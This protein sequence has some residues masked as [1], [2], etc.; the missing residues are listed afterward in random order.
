MKLAARF[1]QRVALS[2]CAQDIRDDALI[3]IVENCLARPF[4]QLRIA[5]IAAEEGMR[6]WSD[7]DQIEALEYCRC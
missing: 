4:A 2:A 1:V 3:G 7:N 5:D 6:D